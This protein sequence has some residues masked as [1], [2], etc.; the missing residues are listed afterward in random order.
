MRYFDRLIGA[1]SD[2]ASYL[3][4]PVFVISFAEVI[5]RYVFH[6]PTTWV[7]ELTVTLAGIQYCI[8]GVDAQ[9]KGTHIRIDSLYN[10][11]PSRV[12]AILDIFA[13]LFTACFLLILVYWGWKQAW[14]SVLMLES[15]G[16][17]WNSRQ[18]AILKAII[19]V[20][21]GLMFIQIVIALIGRLSGRP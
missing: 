3:Y 11:L 1:V 13:L 12:R 16:S 15:S 17:A 9:Q 4:I 21:A 19:P 2:G 20:A 14:P 18:P 10:L 5:S 7:L 8:G 6:T